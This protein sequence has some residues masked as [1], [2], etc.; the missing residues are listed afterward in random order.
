[1]P[2]KGF[3]TVSKALAI[4]VVALSVT[5]GWAVLALLFTEVLS[6]QTYS[7]I[8]NFTDTPDGAQ[9]DAG[10]TMD[11]AGNLYGTTPLGGFAGSQS[12]PAG[13]GTVY[14]LS[15]TSN[16]WTITILHAFGGPRSDGADPF[17]R[18]IFG[19]DGALYGTT[20]SGGTGPRGTVF[21]LSPPAKSCGNV[22]CPWEESHY[23]F[24]ADYLSGAGPIAEVAFDAQGDLYG[25]TDV[26]G[27]NYCRN[28]PNS[29]G[30]LYKLTTPI[31]EWNQSVI[32][33]FEE[34][35]GN[36]PYGG[37]TFD[38]SGNIFGVTT[39]GGSA[40]LGTF[41]EMTESAGS[42][43]HTVLYN[44]TGQSD[45]AAPDGNL[46]EDAEGNL[47]GTAAAGGSG[48]GGTVFEFSP[49]GSGWNFSVLHSFS[50]TEGPV[51]GLTM[52]A[53]GNLYGTTLHD[54]SFGYGNV[55]RLTKSNGYWNYVSLHDFSGGADGW[56][57]YST[58]L[59]D[60]AGNL[61]GTAALGGAIGGGVVWEIT[62]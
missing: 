58:V 62:P 37:I 29:C 59:I 46:L 51:A 31:Q 13:C 61:Y 48:G 36:S 4:L 27:P 17:S 19:R 26:G 54:G 52:D 34:S 3:S 43:T 55:F 5:S 22:P 33:D 16:G 2:G 21:R 60:A 41:Y 7:V 47:Y 38:A 25:T 49:S 44:F 39:V 35:S 32:W 6:A 18:V 24:P 57:S 15:R 45:G 20:Y 8:H 50:G 9:P 14:R 56:A 23:S 28:V 30:V 12:C 42:W 1:M 11:R 10:L 53:N 40:D